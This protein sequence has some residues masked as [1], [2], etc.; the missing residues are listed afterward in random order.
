[1]PINNNN[2][3]KEEKEEETNGI[4]SGMKGIEDFAIDELS[5]NNEE[6]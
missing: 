5:P 6:L 1:M 4:A 3:L 2:E